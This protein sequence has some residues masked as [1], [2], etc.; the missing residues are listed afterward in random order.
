MPPSVSRFSVAAHEP[1]RPSSRKNG[2]GEFVLDA[3]GDVLP[4]RHGNFVAGIAAKT[5]HPAPA[6]DQKGV[7]DFVPKPNVVLF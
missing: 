5:I 6:P 7:G 4:G 3:G 1:P 2:F